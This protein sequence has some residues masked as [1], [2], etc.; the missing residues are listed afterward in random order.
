MIHAFTI[1]KLAEIF[2][3]AIH[4][5]AEH[6]SAGLLFVCLEDQT[7]LLTKRSKEMSSPGA[8][9]IPGGQHSDEDQNSKDTAN[10]EAKE[11]IDAL[12]QNRKFIG[13]HVLNNDN[14]NY[15]IYIYS[16]SQKE[17]ENWTP[18]IK[19]DHESETYKWFPHDK[20]PKNTHLDLN[21]IKDKV[22]EL[23]S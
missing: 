5:L 8:W 20:L 21:W 11:E 9:D 16:V 1:Y 19:L 12:P 3:T 10:R 22:G 6:P 15:I 17:K 4:K 2:E 18:K 7:I 23:L 14:K 13:K